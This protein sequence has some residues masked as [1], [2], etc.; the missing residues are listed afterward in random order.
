MPA[1]PTPS[2]MPLRGIVH[3]RTIEVDGE[4]NLPDGQLVAIVLQPILSPEEAIRRSAGGWSDDP[5]GVDEFVE[6]MRRWRDMDRPAL[7]P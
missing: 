4:L 3:G 7:A 6:E 1:L 2:Q 5:K